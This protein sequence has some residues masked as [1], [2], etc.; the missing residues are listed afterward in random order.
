MILDKFNK[1]NFISVIKDS[2]YNFNF[3][4]QKKLINSLW[5]GKISKKVK[6]VNKEFEIYD[7]DQRALLAYDLAKLLG[8][9]MP[10]TK[11]I[12]LHDIANNEFLL[13]ETEDKKEEY[14]NYSK[15]VITRF[16]G[17]SIKS[18]QDNL[19]EQIDR[20]SLLKIFIFDF[21]IGNFDKKNEDYLID[22][23]NK[24]W[25][26]DYQLYGPVDDSG[27]ALGFCAG[28]YE[29]SKEKAY[30]HCISPKLKPYLDFTS[31]TFGSFL[32]LIENLSDNKII[33]CVNKYNFYYK[34]SDNKKIN[35]EFI[36]YLCL[37]RDS[38]RKKLGRFNK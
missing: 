34:N 10:Q 28:L 21:W 1:F 33:H 12:N 16:C 8:V 26:I 24:L 29:S 11:Y 19:L 7:L 31:Q 20:S 22:N 38:I 4:L 27:K 17:Q 35:K 14:H 2:S 23:S 37:R 5:V 15:I 32:R 13:S 3:L 25:T 36:K 9:S 6:M 30:Q 18:I